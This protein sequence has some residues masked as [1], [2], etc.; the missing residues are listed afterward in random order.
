MASPAGTILLDASGNFQLDSSGNI[1]LSN[2]VSDACCCD[3]CTCVTGIS[4]G[5]A[6]VAA[7]GVAGNTIAVTAPMGCEWTATASDAHITIT[8]GST[9]TGNGTVTY[10]V[11][12]SLSYYSG[13]IIICGIPFYINQGPGS[14]CAIVPADIMTSMYF[15]LDGFT[16]RAATITANA[17]GPDG[18]TL[19]ALYPDELS[20]LGIPVLEDS[21]GANFTS[22]AT[23]RIAEP[24]CPAVNVNWYTD[25]TQ[26]I[27]TAACVTIQYYDA[28]GG[29]ASLAP[30]LAA[31]GWGCGWLCVILASECPVCG[32]GGGG[33]VLAAYWKLS[34][35]TGA[36]IYLPSEAYG[37]GP[38]TTFNPVYSTGSLNAH[39]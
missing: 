22:Q 26:Y 1:R 19:V 6:Y 35:N 23:A 28:L 20:L 27:D 11:A 5:F 15:E 13:T 33:T 39:T 17:C 29:F 24:V 9:G 14:P 37:G 30:T 34:G 31:L 12:A 2:G 4:P 21:G 16:I 38:D 10:S 3:V 18:G 25:P 32:G 36:G 7:G 8:G